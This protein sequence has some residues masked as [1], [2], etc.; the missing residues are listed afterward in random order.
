METFPEHLLPDPSYEPYSIAH[1]SSILRTTMESG[2][3]RQRRTDTS[4]VT[5]VKV[6]W[7]LKWDEYNYFT[8]WHKYKLHD[9]TDTFLIRLKGLRE[10][11]LCQA[12]FVEG[13]F[14]MIFVE[15]MFRV[16]ANLEIY[17]A[18][19]LSEAELNAALTPE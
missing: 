18:P 4:T 9:G 19:T 8:A 3:V 13:N 7:N 12:R 14:S 10:R 2:R 15:G 1:E 5:T 17:N 16:S 11:T 6:L